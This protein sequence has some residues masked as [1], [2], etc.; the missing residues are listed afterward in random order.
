V[1]VAG[2]WVVRSGCHF[3]QEAIATQFRST[4][5]RLAT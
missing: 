5:L 1:M 2:K 3:A 4:L